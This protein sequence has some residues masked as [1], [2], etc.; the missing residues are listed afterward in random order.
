MSW[1]WLKL[2]TILGISI[3][4]LPVWLVNDSY[5][6]HSLSLSLS[7]FKLMFL[8][9]LTLFF[10]LWATSL[11]W[12]N[13]WFLFSLS[14]S[15]YP[16]T[17]FLCRTRRDERERDVSLPHPFKLLRFTLSSGFTWSFYISC[18][19]W[20]VSLMWNVTEGWGCN[21]RMWKM[22]HKT[23]RQIGTE[24]AQRKMKRERERER[25]RSPIESVC[26]FKSNVFCY[27]ILCQLLQP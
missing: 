7:S 11:S 23:D 9:F 1:W 20:R 3:S 14:H 6:N 13:K 12:N 8:S 27:S 4:S 24:G 15:L 21:F 26:L 25:E 10:T 2:V 5:Q 16:V 19:D 17:L 18:F 22:R